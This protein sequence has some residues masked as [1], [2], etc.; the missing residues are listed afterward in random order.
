M[1]QAKALLD[2]GSGFHLYDGVGIEDLKTLS[3]NNDQ[4]IPHTDLNTLVEKIYP[5][6]IIKKSK[7]LFHGFY[8]RKQMLNILIDHY[9]KNCIL[10]PKNV[11][12][13][14][15]N[16]DLLNQI[17]GGVLEYEEIEIRAS[18]I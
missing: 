6:E 11:D 16:A 2:I 7:Y 9:S 8:N 18:A 3:L 13:S 12:V 17:D 5:S 1:S 15:I 14:K 4:F 10:T